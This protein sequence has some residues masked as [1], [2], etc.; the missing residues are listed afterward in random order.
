LYT[1]EWHSSTGHEFQQERCG[2]K[3]IKRLFEKLRYLNVYCF[4][5]METASGKA[6]AQ[7]PIGRIAEVHGPV[8]V[9]ACDTLPPLHQALYANLDHE[10]YL[11]E[12]H[13]HLDERHIRAITL[14]RSAGL[15]RGMA[16]YDTGAPLHVPVTPDCLGRLLNIFG[17]PLDDGPQCC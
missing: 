9:I 4:N 15:H 14:H 11:F 13:Q 8:S 12:V 6:K 5:M 2:C 3:N 17:E 10:T 1:A 7:K 16:V